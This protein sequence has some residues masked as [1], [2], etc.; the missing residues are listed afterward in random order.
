MWKVGIKELQKE[1]RKVHSFLNGL[2]K[3]KQEEQIEMEGVLPLVLD[4]CTENLTTCG[5]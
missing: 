5:D 2:R 1:K 4:H 3:G